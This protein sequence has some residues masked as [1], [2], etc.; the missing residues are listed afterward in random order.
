VEQVSPQA[1][2]PIVGELHD[3]GFEAAHAVVRVAFTA[4]EADIGGLEVA[5]EAVGVRDGFLGEDFLELG[6]EGG[7]E[8]VAAL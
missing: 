2:Q 7:V 4:F 3:V 1:R 8:A 6:C 5:L